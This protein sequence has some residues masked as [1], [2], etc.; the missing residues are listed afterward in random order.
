MEKTPGKAPGLEIA[1]RFPLYPLPLRRLLVR[2]PTNVC[3]GQYE[4][5]GTVK[6]LVGSLW[7]K[8]VLGNRDFYEDRQARNSSWLGAWLHS[9]AAYICA[10]H[11]HHPQNFLLQS[12][13]GPYICTS[14]IVSVTVSVAFWPSGHGYGFV[15]DGTVCAHDR[16][17]CTRPVR[18]RVC[19]S[20]A[21]C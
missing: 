16:F 5:G 19:F 7:Y 20:L 4:D 6:R 17:K 8:T 1:E 3:S 14:E 11:F 15:L 21:E 10:D 9:E 2:F 13:G 18:R 12:R